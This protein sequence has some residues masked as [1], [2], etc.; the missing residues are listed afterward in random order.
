MI[1]LLS[2]TLIEGHFIKMTA[3]LACCMVLNDG[4]KEKTKRQ[5]MKRDMDANIDV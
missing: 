2:A 4:N 3:G 5:N 1:Q